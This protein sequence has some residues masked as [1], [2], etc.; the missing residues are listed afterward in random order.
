M[1]QCVCVCGGGQEAQGARKGGVKSAR[2]RAKG[3][4]LLTEGGS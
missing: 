3:G 4:E 1:F 2:R